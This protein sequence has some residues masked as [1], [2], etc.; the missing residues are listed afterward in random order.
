M[1]KIVVCATPHDLLAA[2]AAVEQHGGKV[3]KALPIAKS[4]VVDIPSEKLDALLN[5]AGIAR[6]E[7]DLSIHCCE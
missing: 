5:L 1:R 7:D 4:L 3:L 2:S 6:I